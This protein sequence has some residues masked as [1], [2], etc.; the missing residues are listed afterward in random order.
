MVV[1]YLALVVVS[2]D[3]TPHLFRKRA[4][5]SFP[6]PIGTTMCIPDCAQA[7]VRAHHYYGEYSAGGGEE[8]FYNLLSPLSETD[9][10]KVPGDGLFFGW[11]YKEGYEVTRE[12]LLQD[13]WDTDMWF[14]DYI[15]P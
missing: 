2:S 10:I 7:I 1:M 14:D 13:G 9:R 15:L 6:I 11:D 4:N 3:Q 8:G 5:L 12:A